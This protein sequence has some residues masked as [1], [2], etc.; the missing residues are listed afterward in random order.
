MSGL[1]FVTDDIAE[2]LINATYFAYNGLLW[3]T[4]VHA[5]HF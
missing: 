2:M 4:T 1:A 5:I 3:G